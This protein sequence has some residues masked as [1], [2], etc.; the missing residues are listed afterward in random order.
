M[1]KQP[2]VAYD[3]HGHNHPR[4]IP[5]P[6]HEDHESL[7]SVLLAVLFLILLLSQGGLYFWKLKYP[8][9]FVQVT[10]FGLWIIPFVFCVYFRFS[11][12]LA[13]WTLFT[14]V[15]GILI[16]KA[17]ETPVKKSTPRIVYGWFFLVY[18][19]CITLSA[20]GYALFMFDF[21]GI[22]LLVASQLGLPAPFSYVGTLLIF[23][24]LYYGVLGRDCAD[25]ATDRLSSRMGFGGGKRGLPARQLTANMCCIC[26]ETYE[27]TD[28]VELNC[29]HQFHDWCIRGWTIVGKK[30]TCPYCAEKVDLK[31]LYA[32]PWQ[33]QGI[34]WTNLLDSLRYL[35]VWNP[36]IL[37]MIQ[38]VLYTIDPGA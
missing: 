37:L 21:L 29:K 4:P 34:L 20:I 6:G 2:I 13:V 8:R 11:R 26:A 27:P 7:H 24:G 33:K 22:G 15:T 32:K 10:L 28:A 35:I 31:A 25:L 5:A 9:S 19:A 36:I 30:D 12:M 3:G 14:L 16:W 18:R 1:S 17:S 23:Y 38:V